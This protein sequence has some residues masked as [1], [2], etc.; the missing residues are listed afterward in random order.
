MTSIPVGS[1]LKITEYVPLPMERPKI[2]DVPVQDHIGWV[3][4]EITE[5]PDIFSDSGKVGIERMKEQFS[6]I[7]EPLSYLS[8]GIEETVT[9]IRNE[10]LL[11]SVL[12]LSL[13]GLVISLAVFLG[14]KLYKRFK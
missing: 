4:K 3:R 9:K 5:L 1:K 6:Y 13:L 10:D 8:T 12:G 14:E 7:L 2:I 11:L